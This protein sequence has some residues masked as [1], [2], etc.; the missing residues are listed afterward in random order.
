MEVLDTGQEVTW[1][2]IQTRFKC[3]SDFPFVIKGEEGPPLR[4]THL[5]P[6]SGEV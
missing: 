5:P 3:F 2:Y 1:P 6:D 4:V